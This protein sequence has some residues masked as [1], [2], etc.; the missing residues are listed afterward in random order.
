MSIIQFSDVNAIHE[1][2][3]KHFDSNQQKNMIVITDK[4]NSKIY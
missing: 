3:S 2:E 4:Y 1:V